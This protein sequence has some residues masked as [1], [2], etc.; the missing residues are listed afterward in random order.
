[1]VGQGID[2]VGHPTRPNKSALSDADVH[3]KTAHRMMKSR[4]N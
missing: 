1:M 4:M 2:K 3:L